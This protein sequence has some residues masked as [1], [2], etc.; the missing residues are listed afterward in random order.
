VVCENSG[1]CVNGVCACLTGFEGTYC[2]KKWNE[3]FCGNWQAADSFYKD[4]ITRF[5]YQLNITGRYTRD[6]FYITGFA[7]TLDTDTLLCYRNAFKGFTIAADQKMDSFLTIKSGSG[8]MDSI[9][10]NISGKY[11]FLR[12]IFPTGLPSKDTT[13]TVA[14][15]W[16]R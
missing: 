4:N 11:V 2:D 9:T 16:K 13:V 3:K 5:H 1:V 8:I 14:F 6:S 15:S 7:D 12:K 10:G